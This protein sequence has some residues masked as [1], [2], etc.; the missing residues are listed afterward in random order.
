MNPEPSRKIKVRQRG[1]ALG[2]WIFR[3]SV[4]FFGLRGTYGLLYFVCFH[5]LLFDRPAVSAALAYLKRRWPGHSPVRLKWDVYRL[6]IS[7]GRTLIDRYALISG[8]ASFRTQI[9][10]EANL[11]SLMAD[12]KGFVLVTAHLGNWQAV[13][14]YLSGFQRKVNLVMRPEDNPAVQSSLRLDESKQTVGIISPEGYLGGVVEIMKA[15]DR[16]EIV[17]LMGDR[18]YGFSPI[19]VDFL[20]DRAAFASGAFHI[21]AMANCRAI[22]ILSAKTGTHDYLVEVASVTQPHYLPGSPKRDQL[23][24]WVQAFA[25]LLERY[26][27]KYPEQC[28]LFHDLWEKPGTPV[29]ANLKN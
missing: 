22:V 4:R 14:N 12:P 28:F 19:E 8:A 2:F 3:V 16:G 23:R 29:N 10:G 24:G 9:E 18:S 11:R 1:N 21:A 15:L 26:L 13:M 7:Q 20:K 5:Y 25:N 17:S 27:E 6:F